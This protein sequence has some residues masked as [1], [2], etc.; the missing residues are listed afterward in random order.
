MAQDL[1]ISTINLR[2]LAAASAF[3]SKEE[4]RYYLCGVCVEFEPRAATYIATDGH[5]IIAY[6]DELPD[7]QEQD[8]A[9]LGKFIIPT[10]HCKPFKLRKDDSALAKIYGEPSHR[11][12]MAHE[13]V[14]VTFNPIDGVYPDWRRVPPAGVPT[15]EVAQFNL[16]YLAAFK[17]FS[18]ALGIGELPF[19][20]H[21][22]QNPAFVW[23]P[24]CPH[25]MG[26]VMPVR[27]DNQLARTVP[28]WVRPAEMEEEAA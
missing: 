23:F 16:D 21:N 11:L 15:G 2:V 22:G 17:K 10:Q 28:E 27:A 9:L 26:V 1:A 12:T 25:I 14:D 7:D 3:A 6:R 19:V 5:R 8:N 20:A 13:F 24:A 4:T 18:K